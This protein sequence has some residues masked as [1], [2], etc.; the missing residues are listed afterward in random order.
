MY[1]FQKTL[2]KKT[3]FLSNGSPKAADKDENKSK[4]EI[5]ALIAR[6]SSKT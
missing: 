6:P 4:Q 3:W 5:V 1:V 2:K